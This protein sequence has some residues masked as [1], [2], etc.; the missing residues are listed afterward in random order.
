[1]IAKT[2]NVAFIWSGLTGAGCRLAAGAPGLP[3]VAG[4]DPG[5][6]PAEALE[7]PG[8]CV[9]RLTR[10]VFRLVDEGAACA[11]GISSRDV[12]FR[13][14][15]VGAIGSRSV[16]CAAAGCADLGETL[17]VAASLGRFSRMVLGRG[18]AAA[19]SAVSLPGSAARAASSEIRDVFFL[20][21]KGEVSARIPG[22]ATFCVWAVAGLGLMRMVLGPSVGGVALTVGEAFAAVRGIFDVAFFA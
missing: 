14:A 10:M 2:G 19:G 7:T 8:R 20:S 5:A 4:A 15:A 3:A 16:I 22:W 9:G 13:V 17:T 11:G 1:M 12:S 18:A 6:P 21:A